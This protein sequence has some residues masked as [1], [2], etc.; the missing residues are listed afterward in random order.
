MIINEQEIKQ[1][2]VLD[3]A[4][5]MLLAAR[6]A[7]KGKGIDNL[8]GIV[9]AGEELNFLADYMEAGVSTHGRMFFIRDAGNI[10]V[11][12]SVVILGTRLVN[13]NLNCGYCGYP[14]CHEK[15][16]ANP[17]SPCALPITDLGIA[18]GS[19]CSIAADHRVDTRVMFSAGIA[20]MQLGWLGPDVKAAYAIPISATSKSPFFDRVSPRPTPTDEKK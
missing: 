12:Q 6:T 4:K 18:V 19:A 5:K 16:L 11:S 2:Q 13:M 15:D 8:V 14:T 10:R 9:V 3:I 20:A 7:P 17:A 1:E